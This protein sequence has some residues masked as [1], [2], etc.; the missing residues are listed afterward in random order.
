M[1]ISGP[2]QMEITQVLEAVQQGDG[3]ACRE[4]FPVIYQELRKLAA[5]QIAGEN[6]QET[7]QTTSLAHEAWLRLMCG[8]QSHWVNRRHFFAAAAE[9]MRRILVENARRKKRLKRGGQLQPV[10]VDEI[11]LPSPM[12]D[13]DFLALH[14]ALDRLEQFDPRAAEVVKLCFFVGLTQ[15]QAAQEL[16]VSLSTVERAWSF[17]RAWLYREIQREHE[18]P[19]RSR[20]KNPEGYCCQMAHEES[21][22]GV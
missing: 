13:E 7:F 16:G 9:A 15:P 2:D 11:D 6:G 4:S 21:G 14:E 12:P 10:Q 1:K 18:A 8:K 19:G 3:T 22:R 20:S 17:A 5:Y